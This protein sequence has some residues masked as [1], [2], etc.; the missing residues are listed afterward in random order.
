VKQIALCGLN[1]VGRRRH[2]PSFERCQLISRQ[3]AQLFASGKHIDRL[4]RPTVTTIKQLASGSE[5]IAFQ[6]GLTDLNER[7]QGKLGVLAGFAGKVT[8][9][10]LGS[11]AGIRDLPLHKTASSGGVVI[12]AHRVKP[13]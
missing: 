3:L 1:V 11:A 6:A 9:M 13:I 4:H 12:A 8:D 2:E 5:L 7:S 10:A